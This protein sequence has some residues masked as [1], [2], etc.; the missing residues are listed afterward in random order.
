[1][2]F[3]KARDAVKHAQSFHIQLCQFYKY[4]NNLENTQKVKLLLEYMIQHEKDLA[5]SLD[6][7]EKNTS[8]GVLDTWLQY[9]NDQ[10]I[11]KIPK[12][13]ALPSKSSIEDIIKLS[14]TFSDEL[15]E[16]YAQV[17]EQVDDVKLKEIFTHLANMQSQ[18]KRKLSMNVDRL[19]DL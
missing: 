1:M 10:S 6:H 13:E 2:R 3:E 15:I 14:I 19:M 16:V 9:A 4:L 5:E 17:A 8:S 11:L 12:K 18:E 7:Y